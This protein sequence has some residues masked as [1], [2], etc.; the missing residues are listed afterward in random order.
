MQE[1]Q[2]AELI[3]QYADLYIFNNRRETMDVLKAAQVLATFDSAKYYTEHMLQV[4]NFDNKE[5]LLA[6]CVSQLDP[7]RAG[8]ALEFGVASGKTINHI[9]GFHPGLVYGFDSFQGLPETW[10]TGFEQ[11]AFAGELP[12]VASN[13]ELVVGW[14]EESLKTFAPLQEQEVSFI[15]M[16][17]DLYSSTK[18]VFEHTAPRFAEDVWIVFDEY[19]NYPGW[20]AH[21]HKAL[22]ELVAETGMSYEYVGI[23]ANSQQVAVK[24]H[25]PHH[26]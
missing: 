2:L 9:A 22:Q 18:T 10:R 4:R 20:Q 24:I 12:S 25:N 26:G 3:G 21:E 5:N 19:W 6:Y 17:C 8:L 7:Q 13:V 23:V 11:G 16:D 14:F 1:H 15:H